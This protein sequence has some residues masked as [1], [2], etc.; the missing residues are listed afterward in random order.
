MYM[1][2]CMCVCVCVCV[3]AC[4]HVCRCWHAYECLD[5]VY[6]HLHLYAHLDM[7]ICVPICTPSTLVSISSICASQLV[8]FFLFLLE[9]FAPPRP[10]LPPYCLPTPTTAYLKKFIFFNQQRSLYTSADD[11]QALE[12]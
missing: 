12:W 8:T 1:C 11:A 3:H 10:T 9:L 7:C 6:A 5:D 4:V 2:A